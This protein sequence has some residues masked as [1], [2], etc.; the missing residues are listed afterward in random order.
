LHD[1]VVFGDVLDV[2]LTR[3]GDAIFGAFELRLQIAVR[4]GRLEVRVLL[5]DDEQAR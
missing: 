5:G 3:D 2:A 1:A 4:V